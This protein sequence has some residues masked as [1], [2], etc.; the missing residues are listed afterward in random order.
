MHS[1]RLLYAS[2]WKWFVKTFRCAVG[3]FLP[4]LCFH[5][6]CH[7]RRQDLLLDYHLV[8][9]RMQFCFGC[10]SWH[11]RNVSEYNFDWTAY[12]FSFKSHNLEYLTSL[13]YL[14]SFSCIVLRMHLEGYLFSHQFEPNRNQHSLMPHFLSLLHQA[15]CNDVGGICLKTRFLLMCSPSRS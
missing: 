9:L 5:W 13:A 1:S 6:Y 8:L 14:V 7:I 10:H 2:I 15:Q 3:I 4:V 11:K 12:L